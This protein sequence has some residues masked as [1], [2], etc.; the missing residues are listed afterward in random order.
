MCQHLSVLS[1]S[2]PQPLLFPSL[3][4][5][6]ILVFRLPVSSCRLFSSL[7]PPSCFFC[8]VLAFSSSVFEFLFADFFLL[9]LLLLLL[10]LTDSSYRRPSSS[11]LSAYSPPLSLPVFLLQS[12]GTTTEQTTS[13]QQMCSNAKGCSR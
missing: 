6:F 11:P 10:C 13:T 8:S 9:F 2:F 4:S 3:F 1:T 5:S 7:P 12:S